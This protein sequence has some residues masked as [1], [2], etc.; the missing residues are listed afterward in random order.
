MSRTLEK[1]EIKRYSS[2][3]ACKF[4][5]ESETQDIIATPLR[6]RDFH[7]QVRKWEFGEG[8]K[9]LS[10]FSDSG[11]RTAMCETSFKIDFLASLK[12]RVWKSR[13]A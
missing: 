3:F 2:K 1:S 10:L 13:R 6:I 9:G 4:A 5:V 7:I 11:A 12:K 8:A